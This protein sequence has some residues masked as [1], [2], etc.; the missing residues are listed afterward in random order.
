MSHPRTDSNRRPHRSK[1]CTLVP[2]SYGGISA[3]ANKPGSVTPFGERSFILGA[4]YRAPPAATRWLGRTALE[5][6]LFALLLTGL[7][8][9]HVTVCVGVSYTS[10]SSLP[11][12]NKG[13]IGGLLSVALSVASRRLAVSQRHVL[14]S[15]DFPPRIAARRSSCFLTSATDRSRTCP[16]FPP[17]HSQCGASA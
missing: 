14:R 10:V 6:H 11:D 17:P 3:E 1:R 13:A 15:P 4:C 2:L 16:G 5:R 12:P 9:T 8:T 7:A